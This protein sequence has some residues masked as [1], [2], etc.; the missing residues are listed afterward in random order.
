[1]SFCRCALQLLHFDG[2]EVWLATSLILKI[3]LNCASVRERPCRPQRDSNWLKLNLT[4]LQLYCTNGRQNDIINGSFVKRHNIRNCCQP[5]SNTAA[6]WIDR[7]VTHE[8]VTCNS[9]EIKGLCR[10]G[11]YSERHS[12]IIYP[13]LSRH[14][15]CSPKE[16]KY[17]SIITLHQYAPISAIF[18]TRVKGCSSF[19][20]QRHANVL[21]PCLLPSFQ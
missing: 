20:L 4:F 11:F 10:A 19:V 16:R 13:P 18:T 17:T 6:Q 9:V 15:T 3:S 8:G 5:L 1:M 12:N 14:F 7:S 2:G 21:S